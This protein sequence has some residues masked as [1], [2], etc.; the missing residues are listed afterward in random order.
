MEKILINT[1]EDL[2]K[3]LNT[4]D[5]ILL[6]NVVNNNANLFYPEDDGSGIDREALEEHRLICMETDELRKHI[7]NILSE[8]AGL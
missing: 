2:E 1:K 7:L 4:L 8:A 3:H 6:M 5:H